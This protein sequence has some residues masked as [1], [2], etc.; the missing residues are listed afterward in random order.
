MY[1]SSSSL[2]AQHPPCS[3]EQRSAVGGRRAGDPQSVHRKHGSTILVFEAFV[4]GRAATFPDPH[5]PSLG[6]SH[7]QPANRLSR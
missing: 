7:L 4:T 5:A 3:Q 1:C 6:T 2:P